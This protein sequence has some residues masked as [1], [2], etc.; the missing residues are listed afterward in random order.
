LQNGGIKVPKP[1]IF[2]GLHVP[3]RAG[4]SPGQAGTTWDIYLMEARL[5]PT[6]GGEAGRGG[7][8]VE[9]EAADRD[10]EA[11]IVGTHYGE[12]PAKGIR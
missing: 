12:S 8:V 11:D 2:S 4:T 3:R 7:E 6:E 5:S 9:A 10:I 1:F